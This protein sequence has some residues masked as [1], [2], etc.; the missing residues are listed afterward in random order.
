[1][2]NLWYDNLQLT[3]K[4][5]SVRTNMRL[6]WKQLIESGAHAT[7]IARAKK[8]DE[9]I[10]KA[11]KNRLT[12]RIIINDGTMRERYD[13]TS[14]AS[15]VSHRLLDPVPWAITSLNLKTGAC[16]ITRGGKVIRPVDQFSITPGEGHDPERVDRRGKAFKRDSAVRLAVLRRANNQCEFCGEEGFTTTNG[17]SFLETHH[18]VPL[19]MGGRDAVSNVAAIC[20]NHHREAHFGVQA[21]IIN[22]ALLERAKPGRRKR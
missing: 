11:Y 20:P 10:T 5:A 19:S 4:T 1:V 17:E 9:A 13:P 22:D 3:R 8:M 15:R 7:R 2:L 21:P 16:T 14:E 12:V 6:D 18:I